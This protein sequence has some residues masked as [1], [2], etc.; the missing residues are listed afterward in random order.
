MYYIK[1]KEKWCQYFL[2]VLFMPFTQS[3]FR[4]WHFL[5][6]NMGQ[7]YVDKKEN[8]SLLKPK[9]IQSRLH[10]YP[11][12]H[13]F[14]WKFK[15]N[16]MTT[17]LEHRQQQNEKHLQDQGK[18]EYQ[19]QHQQQQQIKEEYWICFFFHIRQA[20][21]HCIKLYELFI[22]P[23]NNVKPFLRIFYPF[24]SR[25]NLLMKNSKFNDKKA[26]RWSILCEKSNLR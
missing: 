23:E 13:S 14:R 25:S 20:L 12:V 15:V 8:L 26:D 2:D 6:R 5:L 17:S 19:P 7:K 11:D 22:C 16:V 1:R 21:H 10:S 3:E 24:I 18:Q 9:S 4:L